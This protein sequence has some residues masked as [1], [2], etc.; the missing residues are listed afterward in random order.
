MWTNDSRVYWI[1]LAQ[2]F[3][4]GST[5]AA[6]LAQRY[7]SAQAIYEGAADDLEA[8]EVF[9][10]QEVAKIQKYL[11]KRNLTPALDILSRCESKKIAVLTPEDDS[12]PAPLRSLTDMPLVLYVL[13]NMPDCSQ[14]L[15]CAAVGTRTMTDYGRSVAYSL[16]MGLAFGGAV[17]VSGMALGADSMALIGALDAGGQVIAVLGSGVDVIYPADHKEIY[18]KI[19]SRGAVIS[20]YPP[21]TRPYGGNFPVRNRI[22]SGLSDATVVIEAGAT[23]GAMITAKH[24]IVQGKRLFAVPGKIGD[25]GSE[26]TNLL[27]R[28]GAM[29][30]ISAEDILC[31][32]EF[33]YHGKISVDA[34]HNALRSIDADTAS[35]SAMSR[36]RIGTAKTVQNEDKNYYGKGSYGGRDTRKRFTQSLPEEEQ[37]LPFFSAEEQAR[38]TSE[39]GQKRASASSKASGEAR[40][41]AVSA[42]KAPKELKEKKKNNGG[43][44]FGKKSAKESV[45]ENKEEKTDKKLIPAKKIELDLLDESEIKVYNK[46]KPDVPMLPDELVDEKTSV[47]DV[48][49]ALTMLEMAGA[50]EAGGGGY[51]IRVSPDDI[52]QSIND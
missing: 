39:S 23:S 12:F 35:R 50:V 22:M 51:F 4:Q 38:E 48:M 34:A 24:A 18:R 33:I 10:E 44:F 5:L 52:M 8:D 3:G 41:T 25:E 47:S 2:L 20:E 19:L 1:W 31:E 16:G 28:E 45:K 30:V 40:S 15:L 7:S 29:P 13:G 27:L 26:G 49:S 36:M 9:S 32:F 6:K 37:P 21:S 11:K 43:L 46:M 14:N 42:K 17:V